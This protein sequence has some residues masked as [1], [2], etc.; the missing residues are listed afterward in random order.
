MY[1]VYE[2]YTWDDVTYTKVS[3]HEKEEDAEKE[4]EWLKQERRNLNLEID[5]I[6]Y[7]VMSD[8]KYHLL[9]K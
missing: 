6:T 7:C 5:P 8:I 9:M 2:V 1:N 4:C 3:S